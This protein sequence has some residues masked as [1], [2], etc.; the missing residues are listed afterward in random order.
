MPAIHFT[1]GDVTGGM[2]AHTGINGFFN[3][4]TGEVFFCARCQHLDVIK[5]G[6]MD[7]LP[8]GGTVHSTLEQGGAQWGKRSTTYD[9]IYAWTAA[10]DW[11]HFVTHKDPQENTELHFTTILDAQDK[12]AKRFAKEWSAVPVICR[13]PDPKGVEAM[14]KHRDTIKSIPNCEAP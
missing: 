12:V 5:E 14:R 7:G 1:Y 2:L 10:H 6:C 11:V 3:A 13:H 9:D 4:A 8:D